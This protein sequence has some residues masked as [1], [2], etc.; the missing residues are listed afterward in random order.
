VSFVSV[1]LC[2]ASQRDFV[3]HFVTTQSGNF[4]IHPRILPSRT[5]VF[6]AGC[7]F[8]MT[9]LL[10]RVNWK[11]LSFRSGLIEFSKFEF[12]FRDNPTFFFFFFGSVMLRFFCTESTLHLQWDSKGVSNS[13]TGTVCIIG[14]IK[15]WCFTF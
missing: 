8:L 6:I 14:C 7:V 5:S 3:V 1:T 4:W 12:C 9:F 15:S 11:V 10:T 13:N 2:I